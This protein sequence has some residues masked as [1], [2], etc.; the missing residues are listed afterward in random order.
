MRND[1]WLER[2]KPAVSCRTHLLAAA[3]LWTVVGAVLACIGV[4]FTFM[5]D[6]RV[7]LV[8][9]VCAAAAGILKA[10]FVLGRTANRAIDRILV[11]G[12]GRCLGGFFSWKTWLFVL[13]MVTLG[14]LLRSNGVTPLLIGFIYTAV[15]T[16]L[17]VASR[18]FWMAWRR[19][20]NGRP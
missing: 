11:R 20:E 4:R 6:A 7:A 3:I 17:L 5:G 15:G 8:V 14:R 2:Y 18:H 10:L 13:L 1:H 9:L 12:D 16:A 19:S